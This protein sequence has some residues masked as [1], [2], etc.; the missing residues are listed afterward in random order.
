MATGNGSSKREFLVAEDLV[1]FTTRIRKDQEK[2]LFEVVA[3]SDAEVSR[4]EIVRKA[5]DHFFANLSVSPS[6]LPG[7]D[8][9]KDKSVRQKKKRADKAGDCKT[10]KG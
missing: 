9:K 1:S 7:Y 3:A 4:S 5:I 8:P 2:R 6:M 10:G